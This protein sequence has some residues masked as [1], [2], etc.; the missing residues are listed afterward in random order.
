ME[1]IINKVT[2]YAVRQRHTNALN[3]KLFL[4][5]GYADANAISRLF[6]GSFSGEQIDASH[7]LS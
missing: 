4:H 6:D 2:P 1:V 5:S 7:D 3:N